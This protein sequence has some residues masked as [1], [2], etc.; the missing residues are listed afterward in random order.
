M[1]IVATFI[2]NTESAKLSQPR[3]CPLDHPSEYAQSAAVFRSSFR[4][5]GIYAEFPQCSSMRLAVV[6]PVALHTLG[7][8]ARAAR[9]SGDRRNR[10]DKRHKLGDV[11]AVGARQFHRERD[12]ARIGDDVM[13]RPQLPSIRRIRACFRPP[14][15]ARTD[16]ESTIAREKSILSF[17]RRWFR[18]NRCIVSQTPAFCHSFKRRQHVCPE[19][20]FISLGRKCQGMPL[21]STKMMPVSALRSSTGGLPPLGRGGRS[22]ITCLISFH[23]LMSNSGLAICSSS[24]LQCLHPHYPMEVVSEKPRY[25]LRFCYKL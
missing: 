13:F 9:L 6:G 18:S 17:S 4:Q 16:D 21:L 14:K 7:S 19:P 20:Q 10:L 23:N 3:D 25:K 15:T 5:K 12:A 24:I 22:G 1:N 11:V 8:L 2:T